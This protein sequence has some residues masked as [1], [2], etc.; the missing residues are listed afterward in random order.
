[1]FF[2]R[3]DVKQKLMTVLQEFAYKSGA[4]EKVLKLCTTHNKSKEEDTKLS[5]SSFNMGFVD[6]FVEIFRF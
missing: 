6:K 4:N 1:M 2:E 3:Q 5:D